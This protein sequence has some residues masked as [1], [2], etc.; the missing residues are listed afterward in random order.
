MALSLTGR[1]S[2]STCASCRGHTRPPVLLLSYQG[3]FA[4]RPAS[5]RSTS[6]LLL[7]AGRRSR[8]S[9][10]QE[11]GKGP[12]PQSRL[13]VA[14][15]ATDS[16]SASQ[17]NSSLVLLCQD[18]SQRLFTTDCLQIREQIHQI[19]QRCLKKPLQSSGTAQDPSSLTRYTQA[20][21]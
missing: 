2:V 4:F 17:S 1:L 15:A 11:H 12:E 9:T 5:Q 16:S 3:R 13:T 19:Q 21:L 14:I 7:F 8:C 20:S 6:Q 18:T 10:T